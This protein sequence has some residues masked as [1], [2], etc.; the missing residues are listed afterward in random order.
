MT[1]SKAIKIRCKDCQPEKKEEDICVG[2][3]LKEKLSPLKRIKQYCK[4][5]C[6]NNQN[7]KLCENGDCSLYNYRFG[8]NPELKGNI[9][10]TGNPNIK[11]IRK[12]ISK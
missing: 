11:N 9:N 8:H 7:P 10:C 1:P 5:F 6:C 12:T 4:V 3:F 2:C